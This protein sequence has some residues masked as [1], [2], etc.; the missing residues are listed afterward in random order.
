ML[1]EA[2]AKIGRRIIQLETLENIFAVE[3]GFPDQISGAEAA[4]VI[5]AAVG[6]LREA[7]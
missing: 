2:P 4:E 1:A 7:S 5:S 6:E 3:I